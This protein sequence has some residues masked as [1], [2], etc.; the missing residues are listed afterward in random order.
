[1]AD[2]CLYLHISLTLYLKTCKDL[3][4]AETECLVTGPERTSKC[5]DVRVELEELGE[6]G[7]GWG[8]RLDRTEEKG[9]LTAGDGT[10][11]EDSSPVMSALLSALTGRGATRSSLTLPLII[12]LRANWPEATKACGESGMRS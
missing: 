3:P 9:D 10:R 11:H 6:S 1:M 2:A 8:N 5:W 12:G 4:R 7:V